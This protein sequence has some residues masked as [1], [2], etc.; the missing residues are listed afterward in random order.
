MATQQPK[1]SGYVSKE[2]YQRLAEFQT[3][4]RLKSTSQALVVILHNYFNIPCLINIGDG[5]QGFSAKVS[6][7]EKE[8]KDL[9]ERLE[10]FEKLVASSQELTLSPL[11]SRN[12]DEI[13]EDHQNLKRICRTP[14]I[15]P[16]RTHNATELAHRL[17]VS[18]S[19][20][21]IYKSKLEFPEW[22][23]SRD[24]E[25]IAWIY[26]QNTK[27]FNYTKPEF[28]EREETKCEIPKDTQNHPSS[29]DKS[30]F[31]EL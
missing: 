13:N 16:L 9:K 18:K 7:L 12:S 21:S 3:N 24:P 26:S 31:I 2:V 8:I 11:R 4:H 27:K 22:S 28:S 5:N 10:L 15:T 30:A 20:I 29:A 19:T 23:R 1:I 17:G 14:T 6:I 25:G